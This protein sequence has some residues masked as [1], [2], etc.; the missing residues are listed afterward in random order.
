MVW[1]VPVTFY[2][3][4]PLTAAQ[5]NTYIR[6]NLIAS[7]A[8]AAQQASR[9]IV[10]DAVNSVREVQW[11]RSYAS[12]EIVIEDKFPATE[13]SDGNRIGPSVTVE[14]NGTLFILYDARV[15]VVSGGGNGVYLPVVGGDTA[16]ATIE[17]ERVS[18]TNEAVRTGGELYNRGGNFAL[19]T[20]EPGVTEVVMAYGVSNTTSSAE[21]A[22]RRLTVFPL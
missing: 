9:L 16:S 5:L 19:W 11:A 14:H 6:D 21:Y 4:D 2:D 1:T 10:P 17:G 22:Q 15:R 20:G 13:D 3:D 7:E 12:D 8:G 18:S